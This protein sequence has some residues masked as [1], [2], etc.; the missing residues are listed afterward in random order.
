MYRCGERE[1]RN[2][3]DDHIELN[4]HQISQKQYNL[5]IPY[6]NNLNI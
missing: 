1:G 5:D 2:Y 6:L 4:D 3:S